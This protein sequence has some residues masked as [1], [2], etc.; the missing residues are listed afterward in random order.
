KELAP[1]FIGEQ[2]SQFWVTKNPAETEKVARRVKALRELAAAKTLPADLAKEGEALLFRM[3][4]LKANQELRK[5]YQSLADGTCKADD[6]AAARDKLL[7]AMKISNA[8]VRN[9]VRG[10]EAAVGLVTEKYIRELSAGELTASAIR[11]LHHR[12]GEPIPA[13]VEEA[14]RAPKELT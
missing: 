13:D 7:A 9:Y 4:K 3:P 5:A 10:V 8:E 2:T 12:I 14:L 1:F 6:L 11:G